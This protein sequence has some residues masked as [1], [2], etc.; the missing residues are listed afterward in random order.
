MLEK[1]VWHDVAVMRKITPLLARL[2]DVEAD[3][4]CR[5]KAAQSRERLPK[6]ST[7][8]LSNNERRS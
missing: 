3:L 8:N 6:L 1:K 5:I 2:A 7:G 4:D